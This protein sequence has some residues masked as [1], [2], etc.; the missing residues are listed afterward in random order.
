MKKLFS[1]LL[2]VILI[3]P[4]GACAEGGETM[5]NYL[6]F[7][8]PEPFTISTAST[9]SGDTDPKWSGT[10]E[11]ST[12]TVNWTEWESTETVLSSSLHGWAHRIYIRGVGNS[13][14]AID[15]ATRWRLIGKN[16]RCIGNI[17]NI[18]DYQKVAN[19][20]NIETA[21]NFMDLFNGNSSLIEAPVLPFT[22]MNSFVYGYEV[23]FKGCPNL[24]RAP[25][26]PITGTRGTFY[27]MFQNDTR[28]VAIPKLYFEPDCSISCTQMFSGCTSL[29]LSETQ[30]E[31][32]PTPYHIPESKSS[33]TNM[34]EGTGGPF[35]GTP[36]AGTTYYLHK[37]NSIV[38]PSKLSV[39]MEDVT[40]NAAT[41]TFACS[42]LLYMDNVYRIKAWCFPGGTDYGT[43]PV[44][45]ESNLFAGPSHS[46]SVTFTGLLPDVAY[47]VYAV[48]Y[49]ADG[50]TEHN[51][52]AMF[53]T[54]ASEEETPQAEVQYNDL[55][56]TSFTAYLFTQGLKDGKE[57]TAE[58]SLRPKE[59]NS[60][61]PGVI[62]KDV[63]F[64]GT[65]ALS[66]HSC[67]FTDLLPNTTYT[68]NV[69]LYP[70]D[71][72][73]GIIACDCEV[74]TLEGEIGYDRDS[75][76]LGFASGL[77]CTAATKDGAEYNTWAQG[78]I[79]GCALRR[80]L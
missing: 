6:T 27:Q 4:M 56:A 78:Y 36:V 25:A 55:T 45:W 26:L 41:V 21:G 73:E 23:M 74:T 13:T 63:T 33:Y 69:D 46:E 48:I 24:T 62:Y 38:V 5:A 9:W 15:Y 51:A 42:D 53:T 30:S 31:E 71:G 60:E 66:V 67:E 2:A 65:A 37:S 7:S 64:T 14:I 52:T 28:L 39:G 43:A 72:S 58:F 44:T 29:K 68:V 57:Y 8:S 17:A 18:M 35:T 3:L 70:S 80:A 16:I 75:F 76:L 34:F 10:M 77:G 54:A 11:Y 1:L 59:F 49:G 12:D 19:G 79:A 32:Y 61:I 50:A 47:E 20:E 22:T 40:E